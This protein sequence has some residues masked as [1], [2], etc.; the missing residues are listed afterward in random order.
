MTTRREKLGLTLIELVTVMFITCALIAQLL[1]VLALSA[2]DAN[3]NSCLNKLRQVGLALENFESG[4]RQYSTVSFDLRPSEQHPSAADCRP[5]NASGGK[6]TTGF[7]WV[8]QILPMFEERNLYASIVKE[9][10]RFTIKTGP[11]DPAIVT[12]GDAG[13][14]ASCVPL[15]YLTCPAWRGNEYTN[16]GETVDAG[17]PA[18]PNEPA[19]QGAP[20]YATVDSAPPGA[21]KASF[22]G[23]VAPTCYKPM[24]GTHMKQGMPVE[25]GG[26]ALSYPHGL[27]L[28]SFADGTSKTIFVCESKECGYASWYDGTLNWLVGNDPNQP[29]PGTDGDNSPWIK[30][31]PALNM[32]F[33]PKVANS[34]PYLKKEN[35]ANH[36]QNDVWWG[37]SSDHPNG[38]VYHVFVDNHTL[39]ITDACDPA[40]YLKLITRN[41][42]E[43]IDDTKIK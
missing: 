4:K 35:S 18:N 25:N 16:H 21:G 37:P 26:M 32:G 36:P 42:S 43:P 23:R 33:D 20:E 6:A 8:V 5:A 1:P 17:H 10:Q 7:S 31:A 3:G 29:A 2:A 13:Q 28:G 38:V 39:G 24:V 30:P 34:V 11:F 22:K 15:P 9:S 27:T 40:T 12:S 41:G 19:N 14:H